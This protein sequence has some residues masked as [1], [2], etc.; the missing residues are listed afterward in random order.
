M[1]TAGAHFDYLAEE[2]LGRLPADAQRF[3]LDTSVL[4]RFTAAHAAAVS[5]RAGRARGHPRGSSTRTCSSSRPRGAGTA[6]TTSSTRSCAATSPSA[7]PRS[8]RELNLRAGR[9]WEASGDHQEAVRHFLEAGAMEDA[10]AALEQ[11]AE[12]MVATP[13][14]PDAGR[15]GSRASPRTTWR[16][17]PRIELAGALLSYLAGDARGAFEAWDDAIGRLVADG[18]LERAAAALYRSQQAMLTQG[19]SPAARVAIAEPYLDRLAAAGPA[20]AM[21]T[22]IVAVAHAIGCRPEEADRLMESALASAGRRE[23][24]LLVPCAEITRAFYFDYPGGRLDQALARI[25]GGLARLEPIEVVDSSMLQA[26]GHGFRAA[27]LADT[28]RYHACLQEAQAVIE[29]SASVG[30]RSAPGLVSLWWRLTSLAGPGRLGRGGR[31]RARGA[32]RDRGGRG[33]QRG[34]PHHRGPRAPGRRRRRHRD[35]PGPHRHGAHGGPRVRRLLRDP[36]GAVRARAGGRGRAPR[37]ARPRGGGGGAWRWPTATA[38][39][40]SAPGRACCRPTCTR[41]PR[42]ATAG[43]PARSP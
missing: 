28:G 36:D 29:L 7:S 12:A 20:G 39:T 16:P 41:G 37:G 4:E 3:L 9:A 34:L 38:S 18:D 42:S 23:Q 13:G 25:D 19:V 43:W 40:G 33:H 32:A 5:G 26:F 21:A 31:P 6:I 8:S 2:V 24:A 30:M 22:M 10:A 15:R 1:A 35:R 17:R 14:A 11:V 27:I